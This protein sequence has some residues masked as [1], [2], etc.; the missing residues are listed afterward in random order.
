MDKSTEESLSPQAASPAA[1]VLKS[2]NLISVLVAIFFSIGMVIDNH[3]VTVSMLSGAGIYGTVATMLILWQP[4]ALPYVLVSRQREVTERR[5]DEQQY[6]IY[7]RQVPQVAAVD[8]LPMVSAP[9]PALASSTRFVSAV[10]R[11]GNDLKV[12]AGSWVTQLFDTSTGRPRPNRITRNK[13]QVQIKSP[14]VEVVGYLEGLGI[15]RQDANKHLYYNVTDYPV[16]RDALNSIR[17]GVKRPS[18]EQDKG[19]GVGGLQ[20]IVSGEEGIR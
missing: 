9:P 13:G 14:D 5:R 7:L 16:L 8:P 2:I 19:A 18:L 1:S 6:K 3:S 12:V 10:P 20:P 17:T 4:G 15:V 11:I